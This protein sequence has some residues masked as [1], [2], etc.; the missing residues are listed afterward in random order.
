H[1][2]RPGPKN[3]PSTDCTDN[4]EGRRGR[5]SLLSFPSVLVFSASSVTSANRVAG[6]SE[7]EGKAAKARGEG[8]GKRS[9]FQIR[10]SSAFFRVTRRK[11]LRSTSVNDQA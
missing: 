9:E 2:R 3:Q 11:I 4:T 6:K 1:R 8:V 5:R 10:S 7:I